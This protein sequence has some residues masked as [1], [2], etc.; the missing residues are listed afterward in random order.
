MSV[1][2]KIFNA[3]TRKMIEI[4]T[5]NHLTPYHHRHPAAHSGY[6]LSFTHHLSREIISTDGLAIAKNRADGMN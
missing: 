1:F 6:S 5:R 3:I 4:I 2:K